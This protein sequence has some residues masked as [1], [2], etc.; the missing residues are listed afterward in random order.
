MAVIQMEQPKKKIAIVISN[1]S[2][3]KALI[4]PLPMSE[5]GV[6]TPLYSSVLMKA[7]HLEHNHLTSDMALMI[8]QSSL[9]MPGGVTAILVCCARP[10]VFT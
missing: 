5:H 7:L 10:S 8:L 6:R 4:R 3:M 9:A 1:K 2:E